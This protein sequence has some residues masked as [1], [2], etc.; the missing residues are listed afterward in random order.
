MKIELAHEHAKHMFVYFSQLMDKKVTDSRNEVIG[1]LYDIV[2]RPSEVYPQSSTLIIRK[3][4]WRKQYAPVSW[5]EIV[6]IS[7]EGIFLKIDKSKVIFKQKSNN[8]EELTLR[9]DILDQQVVDTSNHKVIRVNDIHLLE[10]DNALMIA[11]VDI[12]LRGL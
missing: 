7:E 2:V 5:T 11:H 9:R 1:E 10:V 3:G 6:T 12:S 8:K 4:L